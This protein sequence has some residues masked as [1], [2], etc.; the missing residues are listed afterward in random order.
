MIDPIMLLN[1]I[2]YIAKRVPILVPIICSFKVFST[3]EKVFVDQQKPRELVTALLS[4]KK[5]EAAMSCTF[6]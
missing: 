3:V 6:L 2:H 1:V 5:G 4:D